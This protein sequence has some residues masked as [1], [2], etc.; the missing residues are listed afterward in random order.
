LVC[1]T[2][3]FQKQC[4]WNHFLKVGTLVEGMRWIF[5]VCRNSKQEL[6]CCHG[7]SSFMTRW[8]LYYLCCS[9][10]AYENQ[11]NS[12]PTCYNFISWNLKRFY[13]L[14]VVGDFTICRRDYFVELG[15]YEGGKY[16]YIMPKGKHKNSRESIWNDLMHQMS[17]NY[18]KVF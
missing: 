5:Y 14:W 17:T 8:S 11:G 7:D 2:L 18:I 13:M 3:S 1:F 16:S 15:I 6:C 9:T 12:L 4:A 10:Q